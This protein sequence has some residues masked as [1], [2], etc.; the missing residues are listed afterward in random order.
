MSTKENVKRVQANVNKDV[1]HDAET[2]MDELGL[3]PTTV[4]NAL[5]KK[6]VATGSIPFSFSLTS[7]QMN[8]IQIR[9]LSKR[10]PV[11]H[12]KTNKDFEEFFDEDE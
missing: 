12:L 9:T 4:I 2:I 8:A 5:Y 3:T 1:A 6:I 10:K 11:K 7:E